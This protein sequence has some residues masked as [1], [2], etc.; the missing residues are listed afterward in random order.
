MKVTFCGAAGMVTGSCYYLDDGK[1]RILIDC[2]MFQGGKEVEELNR[3]DF[4]FDPASIDYLLVTHAHIDHTGRIPVLCKRGFKGRII[5]TEA[6]VALCGI[7]LPDSGH[8]QE[9]DAEWANR[10]AM[11]AGREPVEPLYTA[12]YAAECMKYF[13]GVGYDRM[14]NLSDNISVSFRDAGHVLG[15]A[16]I[17]MWVRDEGIKIVF[18]GDLGNKNQPIIKD[19]TYIKDADYL[20][21]ESTYG[22]RLHK[23]MGDSLNGLLRIIDETFKK[24]GNVVIPSFA[25]GRT[26]EIIYELNIMV[27]KGMLKGIF[28][29]PVYIDSPL[30]SAA[31]E[32]FKKYRQGY[33][34]EEAMALIMSGDDPLEF[35]GLH[36]T[37]SVEESKALNATPESKIIISASG[38]CDAGRIRHH[39]KHNLWRP[40]CSIIFVGYQAEGTLGRMLLDGRKNVKILGEEISVKAHIYNIDSLS[41]HAD[42]N[43]LIDWIDHFEHKP[44]VAFVVHGEGESINS[45]SSLLNSRYG[46]KT[47]IPALGE[48][49]DLA[50]IQPAM[51]GVQAETMRDAA[52]SIEEIGV[53]WPELVSAI[54]RAGDDKKIADIN[55]EIGKIRESYRRLK[56]LL[57]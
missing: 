22:D 46:I 27:E 57:K 21:I 53:D 31:T 43:G 26:Q 2:G 54:S 45:F 12:D 38:M 17:E 29:M 55:R 33:F 51:A 48:T 52:A 25:V 24:G 30:A 41:G 7:M 32:V 36:F 19:P 23:S 56:E 37:A 35:K 44:S 13:E 10:K 11:R 34:D 50:N 42:R 4:P 39:L 47:V 18:S 9:M 28:K 14:I 15:S 40:E 49:Y 1:T 5:A 3:A 20:F 6:T 8:I 16:I